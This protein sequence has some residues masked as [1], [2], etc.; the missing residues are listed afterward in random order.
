MK[1]AQKE[2]VVEAVVVGAL[3]ARELDDLAIDYAELGLD[4]IIDSE[5]V[6]EIPIV[7]SVVSVA[8]MGIGIRNRIFTRKLLDFL[9]A[10][11][12][13]SEWERQDMVSRLEADP[14]Y[15]RRVGEHLT[16]LL[17]RIESVQKP[18]MV[19][20]VFL[21]YANKSIDA[22]MLLRLNS[23]VERLPVAEIS[24]VRQFVNAATPEGRAKIDIETVQALNSA[25]LT[26][27]Q[28]AWDSL[29]YVPNKT[30]E[31]FVSLN[32]DLA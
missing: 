31:A 22:M 7:K 1:D 21:A 5:A 14:A 10:F 2:G 26:I 8:R 28:S 18:R 23:A 11:R 25:G 19:T 12:G 17:D 27:A 20:R 24:S 15:G 3:T 16:E 4:A 32:L 6:S 13:I 29:G 9:A 30:C